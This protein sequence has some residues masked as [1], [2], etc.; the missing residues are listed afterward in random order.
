M[1]LT[2]LISNELAS[3]PTR[4]KKMLFEGFRYTLGKSK[5][6]SAVGGLE[7]SYANLN[8]GETDPSV[9]GNETQSAKSNG[10]ETLEN[11]QNAVSGHSSNLSW[12]GMRRYKQ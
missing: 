7:S 6:D 5:D 4:P 1:N 3:D 11:E 8:E 12:Y 9:Q 10:T 2:S